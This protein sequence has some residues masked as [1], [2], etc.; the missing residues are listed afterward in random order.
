MRPRER[1]FAASRE[2]TEPCSRAQAAA[3]GEYS[4]PDLGSTRVGV[5]WQSRDPLR[6]NGDIRRHWIETA[7]AALALVSWTGTELAVKCAS[8]RF[9]ELLALSE[10]EGVLPG[11]AIDG[12]PGRWRAAVERALA[13]DEEVT[14]D[15]TLRSQPYALSLRREPDSDDLV[16]GLSARLDAPRP[17]SRFEQIV[18]ESPD[19]IA[20][21]DRQY[22]HVFVNR[23]I[24]P[25]TG[26][27]PADF[28]GKD[29]VQLGMPD[30]LVRYFQGV[31]R[32]VF[33]TGRE[34]AKEF[35][36]PTPEGARSYASRVVPLVE[37]DGSVEVLLSYA[38]DVT[39]RK[40]AEEA[41][42][43]LERKMQ[44]TQRLEGLGLL[45]GGIAHDFNN[46]LTSVLVN[47]QMARLRGS[48]GETGA[49]DQ[50][51]M[52][53]A[54]AA[55]LC[56]QMLAYAGRGALV[57]ERVPIAALIGE[58]WQLVSASAPKNVRLELDLAPSLR[59]VMGDR[60]QLQQVIMNLLINGTEAMPEG[61]G[62]LRVR[63]AVRDAAA[64]DWSGAAVTPE[65]RSGPM[66]WLEVADDGV[67]MDEETRARIFEPFFTTKFTGRGLGLAATLG[68][69]RGHGGGIRVES[70]PGR[71]TTFHLYLPAGEDAVAPAF[72]ASAEAAPSGRRRVLVVDDEPAI[73]SATA[74]LLQASG[75]EVRTA[76]DGMSALDA[77][78]QEPAE[79]VLVDVTMPGLDG[80]ETLA[81]L[82]AADRDVPVVLMSGYAESDVVRRVEGQGA[83]FFL[84]KPFGFRQLHAILSSALDAG[85]RTG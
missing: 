37:P 58:T 79:V 10:A 40:H 64:L 56:R 54:K 75:Y 30:E 6:E 80:V 77:F 74:S 42:L 7:P 32:E 19:I 26:M 8:A 18:E 35:E 84:Q 59:P 52:A 72:E 71:G 82:R 78:A 9:R 13:T 33:E 45:A 21:I 46:L 14:L 28:E 66:V 12:D 25:A 51:E 20:M 15:V 38:R 62:T 11:D 69:V 44:E 29:H 53:C 68:I 17:T 5:R 31:Y 27:A 55:D 48:D 60:S 50:I 16:A 81:R 34:G 57:R 49:H 76:E 22:R 47:V 1:P 70:A 2:S 23:A 73:R 85:P 3:P 41:R 4:F 43:A 24:T 61:A 36:F 67:G 39:E 83:T 63:G 65:T